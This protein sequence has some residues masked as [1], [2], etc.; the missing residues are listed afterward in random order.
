MEPGRRLPSTSV[1]INSYHPVLP[2]VSPNCLLRENCLTTIT[3]QPALHGQ[4]EIRPVPAGE[5]FSSDLAIVINGF[6]IPR[7]AHIMTS[8]LQNVFELRS[9][10]LRSLDCVS[11]LGATLHG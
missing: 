3:T 2:I 7:L 5:Q 1:G 9:R 8:M 4:G 11:G 10:R 6:D